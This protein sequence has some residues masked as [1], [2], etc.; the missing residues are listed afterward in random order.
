[1]HY[2]VSN[3]LRHAQCTTSCPVYYVVSNVLPRVQCTTS[4][5][6]Y[7]VIPNLLRH[8]QCTTSCPTYYVVSKILSHTQFTTSCPMYY[9]VSKVLSRTQFTTTSCPLYYVVVWTRKVSCGSFF[10]CAICKFSFIPS[11]VPSF[12]PSF[13]LM[14][15]CKQPEGVLTESVASRVGQLGSPPVDGRLSPQDDTGACP[16]RTEE[17]VDRRVG[18]HR[19][20]GCNTALRDQWKQTQEGR[21]ERTGWTMEGRKNGMDDGKKDEI[22]I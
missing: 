21:K 9:V 6:M 4:C 13:I 15:S 7:C 22:L 20:S 12:L 16:L 18:L 19:R 3:V 14:Q 1:M 5:P 10:L 11:F 2:V 8:T 17:H